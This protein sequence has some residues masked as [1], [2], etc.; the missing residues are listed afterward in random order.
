MAET[1]FV[2]NSNAVFVC[3]ECK[4]TKSVD[5]SRY[6]NINIASMIKCKCSCGHS[7]HVNLVKRNA[8]RRKVKLIG[9]YTHVVSNVGDN[10]CDE[11]GK[12]VA[13]VVDISHSG[14]LLIF[15]TQPRFQ[16]GDRIMIEFNLNDKKKTKIK[17]ELIIRN[18]S[19]KKIGAEFSVVNPNDP[20]DKAIG[21][22]LL[23]E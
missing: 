17:K 20:C 5:I 9:I 10:F 21:A 3:P 7:Y 6:K 15:N 13:T 14:L 19:G 8:L 22:Y 16:S 18:I 4:K 2:S 1:V 11:I 23:S 12:G